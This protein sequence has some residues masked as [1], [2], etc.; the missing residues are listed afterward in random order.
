M[1]TTSVTVAA[2]GAVAVVTALATSAHAGG[3][4]RID[5]GTPADRVVPGPVDCRA[6][7][8]DFDVVQHSE[9]SWHGT[10]KPDG[11]RMR[12]ITSTA[13]V[14]RADEPETTLTYTGRALVVDTPDGQRRLTGLIRE[15]R[16][17][18]GRIVVKPAGRQVVTFGPD[19]VSLEATPKAGVE[20]EQV[21]A[22][23]AG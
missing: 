22:L 2:V 10:V 5:G 20:D 15:Y 21:C 4:E 8:Y 3:P 14:W 1:R 23:L 9:L 19:G 17:E 6:L 12:H 13:T 16:D 18:S 11:T 7:G